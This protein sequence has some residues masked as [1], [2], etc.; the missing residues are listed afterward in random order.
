MR[1]IVDCELPDDGM[2]EHADGRL[3][4]VR[5]GAMDA[6]SLADFR[7][8]VEDGVI[9]RRQDG[10]R[11]ALSQRQVL[12]LSG[13]SRREGVSSRELP[14]LLDEWRSWINH[15]L[16]AR[17]LA[18]VPTVGDRDGW[19]FTVYEEGELF[20]ARFEE[21][22]AAQMVLELYGALCSEP[23]RC[24]WGDE[25]IVDASPVAT[26]LSHLA[27]IRQGGLG[28]P[29][30]E[31]LAELSGDS[32]HSLELAKVLTAD[33]DDVLAQVDALS[34]SATLG[35]GEPVVGEPQLYETRGAEEA[36]WLFS[37]HDSATAAFVKSALG[38]NGVP[39]K[40]DG[41]WGF[42]VQTDGERRS[43][44]LILPSPAPDWAKLWDSGLLT[45]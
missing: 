41:V 37:D 13:T 24:V 33:V 6:A 3:R 19:T 25:C 9:I 39:E 44:G 15:R 31:G 42:E 10:G 32:P 28:W 20:T 4:L 36:Y 27:W 12:Y 29:S 5:A 30:V 16:D 14:H 35:E 1:R 26:D 38:E 18:T 7:S 34:P 8:R 11:C 17:S 22:H 40:R 23:S 2:Y 43:L 21:K 45:A